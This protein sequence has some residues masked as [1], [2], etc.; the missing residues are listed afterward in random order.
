MK[1]TTNLALIAATRQGAKMATCLNQKSW[2]RTSLWLSAS[3]LMLRRWHSVRQKMICELCSSH[4]C[5]SSMQ[6][7]RDLVLC[8]DIK[9]SSTKSEDNKGGAHTTPPLGQRADV[10]GLRLDRV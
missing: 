7:P 3:T 4:S 1:R 10:I 5:V 8:Y 6:Q 9:I 2:I